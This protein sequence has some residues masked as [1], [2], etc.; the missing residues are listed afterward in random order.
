MLGINI[1]VE[2]EF[3]TADD[4]KADLLRQELL[5]NVNEDNYFDE[6]I[7]IKVNSNGDC[8]YETINAL[9]QIHLNFPN[10]SVDE[11]RPILN[12]LH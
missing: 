4:R 9:S 5:K 12:D 7:K 6:F 8:G 11:L 1:P 3:K 2:E 10:R